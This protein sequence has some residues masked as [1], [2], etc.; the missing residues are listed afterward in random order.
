MET[1]LYLTAK[2]ATEE[3]GISLATLYSYVSRGLIRSDAEPGS[4][5]KR[6]WAEDIRDMSGKR[7]RRRTSWPL[8]T[9][10]PLLESSITLIT[11]DKVYYRGRDAVELSRSHTVEQVAELLWDCVGQSVFEQP[12]PNKPP[13]F[14]QTRAAIADLP[15]VERCFALFP[16]IERANPKSYVLTAEGVAR[17]GAD[18]LRWLVAIVTGS[19]SPSVEPIHTY[20]A[21]RWNLDHRYENL[22]RIMLILAADHGLA[23]A[24]FPVRIVASVGASPY[25][26]VLTG[27]VAFRGRWSLP[28]QADWINRF[29]EE[30]LSSDNPE[31]PL[32]RR[33]KTGMDL[34]GFTTHPLHPTGDPRAKALLNEISTSLGDDPDV[35]KLNGAIS[36]MRRLTGLEPNNLL[37]TTFLGIKAGLSA[38]DMLGPYAVGRAVGWIAHTLEE[39]QRHRLIRPHAHY[40][41]VLPG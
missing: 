18:L 40:V 14:D 35:R 28:G 29:L 12:V 24:T 22:F 36:E 8:E 16:L 5:R 30:I 21:S 1:R 10:D 23:P 32:V 34:P 38:E 3:L 31:K 2:E 11:E 41:G 6:Y 27:L 37:V 33:L 19:D 20:L 15:S 7:R 39:Y 26:S 4:R 13:T 17:T 9:T 25:F